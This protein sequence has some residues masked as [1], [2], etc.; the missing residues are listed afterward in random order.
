MTQV[1]PFLI[2]A[3][4][5]LA[6]FLSFF[7]QPM[8]GKQLLPI[9]GGASATWLGT[10]LYFQLTLLLG[11]SWAAWLVRQPVRVQVGGTCGLA[12]LA[13]F[14]FHLPSE[15][16][17]I[18]PTIGTV[19]WRLSLSSLP[20]MLLLFSVSPLLHGWLQRRGQEVPYYLYAISNLG[21]LA[22]VLLYP[23]VIETNLGIREQTFYCRSIL[24]IT[25][26]LL[27]A[28]GYILL[29][30]EDAANTQR[31]PNRSTET[32]SFGL[33]AA[34]LGLSAL[35]CIGML[36]AT[37]HLA[38]EIGSSP[39]AWVGPFGLYLLS[40]TATFSE[41]WR[42]WMTLTTVAW[43]AVSL[44]G[45][46]VMKG[47]SAA[48]VDYHRAWWL[49]SLTASGSF[50]GNALLHSLRP[51]QRF[52]KY[53]LFMAAGGVIGGLLSVTVIPHLFL[54]T[55]PIEFVIA[56]GVLLTIGVLWLTGRREPSIVLVTSVVLFAPVL[57][58]GGWQAMQETASGARVLHFRDLYG[59]IMITLNP[60]N[61]VLSSDTTTHG[62]QLNADPAARRHPTL[63]YSEGTGVGRVLERLQAQRPAMHVGVIGLGAGTLAAYA[64]KGD[65]Y[66]FWEI[67]P[68]IIRV[69]G[70]YFT[71]VSDSP[72]Q[73]NLILGDGRKA[74]ESSQTDYDV[75]VIDAFTGDG[76]PSHL[77]TR[78]A[79][80]QYQRRLN[81]R[82]GLLLIHVSTR[83]TK[84]FP[85]VEATARTLG[86]YTIDVVSDISGST[87]DRDWDPTHTE[88][89]I[90]CQSE[91]KV[92]EV[93][94]WFPAEED[95]GRVKRK[96]TT[97]QPPL[98][99][100]QLIW[101]DDRNAAIDSL[102][103]SRFLQGP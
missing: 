21:S 29:R 86:S 34:W 55:R 43:L 36:G 57:G 63:Y 102:D 79:I 93:A 94:A 67:D 50:L 38:S 37:Y 13:M 33:M 73:I 19:L 92:S 10:M 58:L 85:V 35:T 60:T 31:A 100:S 44:T 84:L 42:R 82:D 70:E 62:S 49:L 1:F 95:N 69:A 23:F 75:L 78:E 91:K 16:A 99:N 39:V 17:V 45:F 51:A 14:T 52:E 4:V 6:S 2:I 90:V 53:Y 56:S 40:F 12:L 64:R 96:I 26:G 11:Y 9:Y 24:I 81:A 28:A 47:F 103:L 15:Q 8:M 54:F 83:Y 48:T 88:Y 46:M 32:T 30:S 71:Y 41:R 59:H 22:A 3:A 72:G 25:S 74:V 66:D 7:I 98:V 61:A 97:V 80:G 68:K 76:I 65:V 89:V 87:A 77:L 20:A 101:S 18:A 5:P 27:A